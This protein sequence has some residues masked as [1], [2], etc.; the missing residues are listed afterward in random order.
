MTLDTLAIINAG[1][2][3]MA[4]ITESFATE[5]N[6]SAESSMQKGLDYSDLEEQPVIWT[7]LPHAQLNRMDIIPFIAT[8]PW[9]ED[10]MTFPPT[11]EQRDRGQQYA[12]KRGIKFGKVGGAIDYFLEIPF[13]RFANGQS[14]DAVCLREAFN[15]PC[16]HCDRM[17]EEYKKRAEGD[18]EAQA[19]AE[20]LKS[21]W[22]TWANCYNYEFGSTPEAPADHEGYEII[23]DFGRGAFLSHIYACA[24][25]AGT[26]NG[27]AYNWSHPSQ[28]LTLNF[29]SVWNKPTSAKYKKGHFE[30]PIIKF[31]DRDPI[32]VD[33]T[34]DIEKS[35][36]F[37]ELVDK[38]IYTESEMVDMLRMKMGDSSV[39]KTGQL[40]QNTA[41][42]DDRPADMPDPENDNTA[43]VDD[44]PIISNTDAAVTTRTAGR[45][46]RGTA[47][48]ESTPEKAETQ[49]AAVSGRSSGRRGGRGGQPAQTPTEIENAKQA[50]TEAASTGRRGGRR[51]SRR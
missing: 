12:T 45:R 26:G 30:F 48:T 19:R 8:M 33:Y 29:D 7:P 5:N 24:Q 23:D 6:A 38:L 46:G 10:L 41:G 35:V 13:H 17:F 44:E 39:E 20:S 49:E 36:R 22:R 40:E 50:E 9:Y 28:G 31:V 14:G 18:P 32:D 11:K 43:G 51:G 15:K 25:N 16:P 37:D 47:K 42:T 4:A 27:Y 34:E 2:D 3:Q 21:K 1:V